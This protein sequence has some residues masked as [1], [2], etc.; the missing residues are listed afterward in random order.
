MASLK[1][2][3]AAFWLLL[4]AVCAALT[5]V[6]IVLY[7]ESAGAQ[8]REASALT[9]RTCSLIARRY[10]ESVAHPASSTAANVELMQVILQLAL[11]EAPHVE[12]GLWSASSG[13]VAYA[14]PTYEGGGFKRDVPE[15]ERAHIGEVAG[16]AVQSKALRTDVLKG[17]REAL[18]L[19]ACPLATPNVGLA[20]W[21]M[22]RVPAASEGALS[23]VRIGVAVLLVGLLG[24][25]VW[26][27]RIFFRAYEHV[28]RIETALES[29]NASAGHAEPIQDSGVEEL[30]RIVVA[31]N[32]YSERLTVAQE[33]TIQLTREN[34]HDQRLKSLGR[35]TGAIAHEIRNPIAAMRLKA[36]N[37]LAAEPKGKQ[38]E[39]LQVIVGQIERLDALVRQLLALVQPLDLHPAPVP[40]KPWLEERVQ[41]AEAAAKAKRI[42]VGW[43]TEV[44]S[45]RFDSLHLGRAMDNLID[46]AVRHAKSEVDLTVI[47]AST[48]R[49]LLLTVLDDGEGVTEGLRGQLFEPFATGHPDGTGLG[50]AL[51]REVALAHGGEVRY[52]PQSPGSRFEVEIPWHES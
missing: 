25:G 34:A 13:F 17:S 24:C 48:G 6:M 33:R 40:L 19:T 30:D 21:T 38:G 36:E 10:E 4:L 26:L 9:Q 31:I 41:H 49:T 29:A 32:R 43:R 44:D 28:R 46:N 45:A 20:V 52:R 16:S 11:I 22:T 7:R 8:T 37:A 39:A 5:V 15:A 35:M 47:R 23:L 12:G 2:Q 50:L 42:A 27:G 51:V 14:Y 1:T 18:V 3:V